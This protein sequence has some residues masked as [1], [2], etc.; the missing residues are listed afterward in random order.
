MRTS[1]H[2]K[3]TPVQIAIRV[4]SDL[5]STFYGT[6]FHTRVFTG[7]FS[8]KPTVTITWTDGPTVEQVDTIAARYSPPY[9]D[10]D[11]TTTINGNTVILPN[12]A[13]LY[14]RNGSA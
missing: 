6:T 3:L 2:R 8:G 5:R 13:F 9:L 7:S 14:V 12:V 10:Q 4:G 11:H 1:P